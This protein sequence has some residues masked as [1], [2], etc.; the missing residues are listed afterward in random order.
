MFSYN[1]FNTLDTIFSS[2]VLK[3]LKRL[4][5]CSAFLGNN[6]SLKNSSSSPVQLSEL[7]KDNAELTNC[8]LFLGVNNQELGYQYSDDAYLDAVN[9]RALY[10][11]FGATGDELFANNPKL[12]DCH[13]AFAKCTAQGVMSDNIFG[14]VNNTGDYPTGL[15]NVAF[16]FHD[17]NV[18][19]VLTDKLFSNQ[20]KLAKVSGFVSG[21]VTGSAN[22]LCRNVT[23]DMATLGTLF[24]S[25]PLLTEVRRFF[26]S[27][28]VTGQIPEGTSIA[29]SP[30]FAKNVLLQRADRLFANADNITGR[31]PATLFGNCPNL[32]SCESLFRSCSGITDVLPGAGTD[33]S[34]QLFK[35]LTSET[36]E[37]KSLSNVAHLFDGCTGIYSQIPA[38][39]F[40]NT[41]GVT[42]ASYAFR[43]CGT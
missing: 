25:N 40:V 5:N 14:G 21:G 43:D 35:C 4:T 26:E 11:N 1:S 20:P 27:T 30:L 38:N 32:S 9:R 39:L 42:N 17:C 29:A 10:I 28:G 15:T 16:C 19:T 24:T 41:P 23:G 8:S 33:T 6:M 34:L 36:G 22:N 3:G 12:T 18:T 31:V 37:F 2:T 13:N 7:F